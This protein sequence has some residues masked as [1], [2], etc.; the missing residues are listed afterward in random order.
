MKKEARIEE[1]EKKI[2][3]EMNKKTTAN[4]KVQNKKKKLF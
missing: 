1:L 2:Q 4:K 3:E